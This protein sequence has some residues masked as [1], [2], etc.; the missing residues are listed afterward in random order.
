MD[1]KNRLLEARETLATTDTQSLQK[2]YFENPRSE[3]TAWLVFEPKRDGDVLTTDRFAVLSMASL[4]QEQFFEPDS[5]DNLAFEDVKELDVE[6][7]RAIIACTPFKMTHNVAE[8]LQ[9]ATVA[10]AIY[11]DWDYRIYIL[12]GPDAN[13]CFAWMTTA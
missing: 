1:L 6:K 10:T 3:E 11:N 5:L 12:S 2:L 7:A 8:S 4:L 13:I 9:R